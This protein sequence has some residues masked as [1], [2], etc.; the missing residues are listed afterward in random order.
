M[1]LTE[2]RWASI[3][4]LLGNPEIRSHKRTVPSEEPDAHMPR[5][6]S[7]GK[8]PP[9]RIRRLAWGNVCI[10][11]S[12]HAE[13]SPLKTPALRHSHIRGHRLPGP[14]FKWFGMGLSEG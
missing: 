4:S 14:H 13:M 11:P 12:A 8:C 6:L 2:L 9:G 5:T 1:D 3:G 7:R 10:K